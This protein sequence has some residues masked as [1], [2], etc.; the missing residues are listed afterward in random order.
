[1]R[2]CPRDK[3]VGMEGLADKAH[4]VWNVDKLLSLTTMYTFSI[5]GRVVGWYSTR[6]LPLPG[7]ALFAIHDVGCDILW[8][9]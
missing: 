9:V 2:K 6:I 3:Y 5:S 8:M 4:R 1:M 7:D